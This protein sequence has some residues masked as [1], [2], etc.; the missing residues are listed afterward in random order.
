MG[1]VYIDKQQHARQIY[2]LRETPRRELYQRV[3]EEM[4]IICFLV[5]KQYACP[6]ERLE[7]AAFSQLLRCELGTSS[8]EKPYR[9]SSSQ[10]AQSLPAVHFPAKMNAS[11]IAVIFYGKCIARPRFTVSSGAQK[12][13]DPDLPVASGNVNQMKVYFKSQKE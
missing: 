11:G 3:D 4:E 1:E 9:P 2:S 7:G 12:I 10:Y 8:L 13:Q 5:T 6:E